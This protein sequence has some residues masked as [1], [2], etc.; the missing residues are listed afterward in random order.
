M[1]VSCKLTTLGARRQQNAWGD[2]G[3]LRGAVEANFAAY[4]GDV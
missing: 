3:G 4:Q 1:H 2:G